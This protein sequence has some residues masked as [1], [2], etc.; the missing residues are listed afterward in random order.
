MWLLLGVR[1]HM[2]EHLVARIEAAFAALAAAPTAIV[3]SIEQR[4]DRMTKRD[5]LRECLQRL[6]DSAERERGE[7]KNMSKG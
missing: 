6:K 7:R 2:D 1:A 4:S 3:E 5:V